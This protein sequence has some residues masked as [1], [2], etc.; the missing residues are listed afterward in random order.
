MLVR[1]LH[2]GLRTWNFFWA[3]AGVETWAEAGVGAGAGEGEFFVSIFFD[4]AFFVSSAATVALIESLP[5]LIGGANPASLLEPGELYSQKLFLLSL[6]RVSSENDP[7]FSGS[8]TLGG[9]IVV[10]DFLD[11][12]NPEIFLVASLPKEI[13]LWPVV[14]DKDEIEDFCWGS[15]SSGVDMSIFG[16]YFWR[17]L[18]AVNVRRK[19]VVKRAVLC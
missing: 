2:N 8:A 14:G 19:E 15:S 17:F 18:A 11:S 16:R 12:N 4:H 6:D 3:V 7:L 9:A 13:F 1:P 5:R 10:E